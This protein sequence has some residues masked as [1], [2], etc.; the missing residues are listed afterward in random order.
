MLPGPGR[1]GEVRFAQRVFRWIAGHN[2]D[3]AVL[4]QE[5]DDAQSQHRCGLVGGGPEHVVERGDT[6]ELAAEGIKLLG[7]TRTTDRCN[8]LGAC[9]RR[10]IRYDDGDDR[11]KHDG[12]DVGGIGNLKGVVRLS[13]EK[14]VAKRGSAAGEQRGPQAVACGNADNDDKE[15]EI[16]I[17]K[18]DPRPEQLADTDGRGNGEKGNRVGAKIEGCRCV[19]RAHR[20]LRD[21]FAG[22]LFS[23]D[24]MNADVAGAPHKLVHHGAIQQLEP[25]RAVRFANSDMRDIACMREAQHVIGNAPCAR[26]GHGLAAEKLRQSQGIGDPIAFLLAQPQA[27]R[28]FHP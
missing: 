27:A 7:R 19:G 11:E 13:E 3:R 6:G 5:Q 18:P 24:D 10:H 15:D 28:T 2:A 12:Y 4:R 21:R 23:G 20:L 8:G 22:Q 1:G 17:L 26:D 16:D 25:S 9:T 14:I